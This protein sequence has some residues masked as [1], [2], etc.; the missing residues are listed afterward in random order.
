VTTQQHDAVELPYLCCLISAQWPH[1]LKHFL[2]C[3]I[4]P[5]SGDTCSTRV[6]LLQARH[7]SRFSES[8]RVEPRT[9]TRD[10]PQCR[11]N[12]IEVMNCRN[13][14]KRAIAVRCAVIIA[15]L[16]VVWHVTPCSLVKMYLLPTSGYK[17][18]T[19]SSG[20]LVCMYRTTR[21]HVPDFSCLTEN[22]WIG[23]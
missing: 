14:Y 10:M 2:F 21:R 15:K 11:A 16:T 1:R 5:G 20:R 4:P 19:V 9:W 6:R 22:F 23:C 18:A 7:F 17:E 12:M 3:S 8:V 13:A